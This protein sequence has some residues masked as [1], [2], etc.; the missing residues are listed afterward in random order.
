MKRNLIAIAAVVAL[1]VLLLAYLWFAPARAGQ[2]GAVRLM[3][4]GFQTNSA[5]A[6]SAQVATTNAGNH[7]L[8][9]AIGTQVSKGGGVG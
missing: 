3:V 2:S 5:G 4:I 1:A 7:T 9:I 6:I 8:K